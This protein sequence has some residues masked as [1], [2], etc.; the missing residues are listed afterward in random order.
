M[1]I[2]LSVVKRC[3]REPG[4]WATSTCGAAM[5]QLAGRVI[6]CRAGAGG[7]KEILTSHWYPLLCRD[8]CQ[9]G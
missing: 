5:A 3:G 2:G 8:V 6:V 1:T 7:D 4:A 9:C